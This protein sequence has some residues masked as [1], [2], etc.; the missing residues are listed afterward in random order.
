M[1]SDIQVREAVPE[2]RS[3]ICKLC[4]LVQELH[5]A[6]R[7][8]L[9]KKVTLQDLESWF[10]SAFRE[11]VVKAWVAEVDGTIVGYTLTVQECIAET[12]FTYERRWIEVEQVGVHPDYRRQGVARVLLNR[13]LKEINT[14][15]KLP[16][17]L[18]T[19]SFNK[20]ASIAFGK[21]GFDERNVRREWRE[22]R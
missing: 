22:T 11:S 18:N 2:D 7:P 20:A 5:V 16:L 4:Q 13:I 15:S 6:K 17:E 3:A 14:T 21:L 1:K 19:W 9:F 8:E 10:A 12:L